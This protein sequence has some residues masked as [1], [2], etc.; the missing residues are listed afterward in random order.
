MKISVTMTKFIQWDGGFF[1]IACGYDP[2]LLKSM[3]AYN[4][5]YHGPNSVIFTYRD[6]TKRILRRGDFIIIKDGE[7]FQDLKYLN[8]YQE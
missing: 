2:Y 6:G 4:R 7:F 5:Q 1:N 8:L 3:P